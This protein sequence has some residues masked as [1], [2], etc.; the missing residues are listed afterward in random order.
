MT[1]AD[2]AAA[3]AALRVFVRNRRKQLALEHP[4][5]DWMAVDV[6]RE[7]LSARFPDPKGKV[8]ALYHG[9]GSEVSARALADWMAEQGWSLAL[10]SVEGADPHGKG[11]RMVFRA[12]T[13]G[14]PL[15]RDA[16][17]LVAP[18]AE[19][20]VVQP[21]LVITP[22]LAW[23]REGRRLGQGGGYYDRALEALRG[24]K[25]VFVLGLAYKGQETHGLPDERHDQRLDAILTEN[26]YIEVRKD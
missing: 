24:R 13:P 23:D 17:G 7:P 12:W 16:I 1:I 22:L 11:G 4:E 10:P 6:A 18:I 25:E 14:E 20:A 3:K 26:E 21:D 5:A 9:L 15:A 19:K 8:A 2:P